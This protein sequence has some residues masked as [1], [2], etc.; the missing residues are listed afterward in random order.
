VSSAQDVARR[1]ASSR[2]AQGLPARIEDDAVV[3]RVVALLSAVNREH[4]SVP[5]R[6]NT[7]TGTALPARAGVAGGDH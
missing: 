6:A 4:T 5:A 3:A 1:V 2:A 7:L